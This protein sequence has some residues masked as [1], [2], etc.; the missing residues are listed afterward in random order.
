[1]TGPRAHHRPGGGFR[2][3]WPGARRTGGLWSLLRWMLVE[4]TLLRSRAAD[5]PPSAFP[6]AEPSFAEPRGAGGELSVTWVGHSSFLLQLGD[7]NVLTDPV[8]SERASPLR[9]VGPRRHTAPGFALDRLP[10]IDAVLLSHDHYDHLDAATVRTLAS[11]FPQAQWAVPLGLARWLRRKGVLRVTEHDWWDRV[12]LEPSLGTAASALE[13]TCVP[14]QHFSGR[15]LHDRDRA[16]WCGWAARAG[17]VGAYFAGD[18]GDHGAWE[19]IARGVGPVDAVLMPI[20]AY[21]PRWFMRPVHVDADEA[22]AAFEALCAAGAADGTRPAMVGMHWG[23]FK[24]TDEALDEP[25]RRA[26]AA[27]ARR[28]LPD[29]RLWIRAHGETRRPA[30]VTRDR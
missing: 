23:T 17:G 5:P 14:A 30:R 29:D 24:L 19:E 1:M 7:W 26:R 22:V 25:P 20:G 18:T 28:A 12:S 9:R 4:R 6:R 8:W 13:L 15:G 27:W 16:L 3:P 21:E 10:C 11:R 2:N